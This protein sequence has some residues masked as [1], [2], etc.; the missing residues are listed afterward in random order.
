MNMINV[1]LDIIQTAGI[2][3]FHQSVGHTAAAG[4]TASATIGTRQE[5][6]DLCD[7]RIF[8]DSK[9]LGGGKQHQGC[10]QADGSKHNYCNHEKIH[11]SLSYLYYL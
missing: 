8:I 10:Y 7:A 3:A 4:E 1:E 5:L 6:A 9:F 11:K 2:G